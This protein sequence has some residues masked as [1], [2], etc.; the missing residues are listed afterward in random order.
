M[1]L[2][3]PAKLVKKVKEMSRENASLAEKSM[4]LIN[5]NFSFYKFHYVQFFYKNHS[6]N[7]AN[8]W[9]KKVQLGLIIHLSESSN[10]SVFFNKI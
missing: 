7:M 3:D 5:F 10:V 2:S 4:F 6:F 8:N 9:K 1:V